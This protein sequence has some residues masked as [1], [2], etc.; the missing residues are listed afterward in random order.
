MVLVVHRAV[1]EV[2]VVV[3]E[4]VEDGGDLRAGVGVV[5]AV[6]DDRRL[7][8]HD[9]EP[10]R[11]VGVSEAAVNR[12]LADVGADLP[13]ERHGDTGVSRLIR[14]QKRDAN[15]ERLGVGLDG[16]G[17]LLMVDAAAVGG[18]NVGV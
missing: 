11:P 4:L 14:A 6:E 2:E 8:A 15:V 16:D 9:L 17:G 18:A 5:R 13:G 10:T 7:R 1:D 3:I 12:L